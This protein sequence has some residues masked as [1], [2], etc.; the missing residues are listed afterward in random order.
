MAVLSIIKDTNGDAAVEAAILFPIM[1]MIFA[2]LVLLATYLQTKAVLQ[3]ATQYAA[4]AIATEKSDTWL[5]YDQDTMSYNWETNKNNLENVYVGL[6]SNG[7]DIQ[8]KGEAV[9]IGVEG[10]GLS[11][12]GGTLDVKCRVEDKIIYKE[13]VV[14]AT[15]TFTTS[16]DLSFIMFPQTIPIAVTSTAVV[17]NGD[18]FV[19][20][21][22]L[23]VD[24]TEYL[25]EKYQLNDITGSIS[26]FG[27]KV[28]SFFGW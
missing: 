7:G 5:F 3:R 15:R 16:I 2:A 24:F 9:V 22:D 28:S 19:R 26:S 18:E 4:T 12:K 6:F 10:R 23:A 13:I 25:V 21:I 17:Q 27:G 8:D 20:N 1:I 11:L 14:T